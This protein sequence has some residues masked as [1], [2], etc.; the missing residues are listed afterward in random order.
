MYWK[1][2]NCFPLSFPARTFL[3]QCYF[4]NVFLQTSYR[5]SLPTLTKYE[6][7]KTG[8]GL[9]I[10]VW[11]LWRERLHRGQTQNPMQLPVF[12]AS[13]FVRVGNESLWDFCKKK[14]VNIAFW[15]KSSSWE[16]QWI[17]II[18]F[19]CIRK[20]CINL[21]LSVTALTFGIKAKGFGNLGRLYGALLAGTGHSQWVWPLCGERDWGDK[22]LWGE[23]EIPVCFWLPGF[24][25]ACKQSQPLSHPQRPL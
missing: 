12:A 2:D 7:A 1:F 15:K 21:N 22:R 18:K 23:N 14:V 4:Y 20:W 25:A 17:T 8:S 11:P 6:A 5:L 3:S 9:G 13:Y 24:W 10:C 16:E 19:K